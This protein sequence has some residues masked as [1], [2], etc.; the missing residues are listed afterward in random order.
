MLTKVPLPDI[1]NADVLSVFSSLSLTACVMSIMEL[2]TPDVA[3]EH[4]GF[5]WFNSLDSWCDTQRMQVLSLSSD[6]PVRGFHI[7]FFCSLSDTVVRPDGETLACLEATVWLNDELVYNPS[8]CDLPIMREHN[9][10][11]VFV[12]YD[13][14]PTKIQFKN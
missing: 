7:R 4:F 13:P 8:D 2:D 6:A 11:L 1:P 3:W 12:A 9:L 14:A 10:K 5:G